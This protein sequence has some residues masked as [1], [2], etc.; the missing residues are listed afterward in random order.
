ML[1]RLLQRR[2]HFCVEAKD[3]FEAIT[4]VKDAAQECHPYD[5]IL[6]D[7]EMPEM[8]GPEAAKHIRALGYDLFIVGITTGN[9]FPD[10][11]AHFKACGANAVFPKPLNLAVLEELWVE[12]CVTGT[13]S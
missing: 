3:G 7:Y 11:V 12:H 10:D 2:D 4:K 13:I 5:M 1:V 8:D 9:L 6:M